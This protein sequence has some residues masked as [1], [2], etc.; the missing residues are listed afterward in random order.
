MTHGSPTDLEHPKGT[1]FLIGLYGL[2]FVIGWFA[3]YVLLYLG[4]GG[5]TA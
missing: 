2:L 3:I 5:V 1:L 4:R